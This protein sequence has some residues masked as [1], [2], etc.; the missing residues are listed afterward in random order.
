MFV[1]FSSSTFQLDL[2][3][4]F[5]LLKKKFIKPYIAER[6]SLLDVP[7]AQ[8]SLEEGEYIKGEIVCLPWKKGKAMTS[9]LK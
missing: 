4:L 9:K 8:K 6:I 7:A 2:D 1:L 5:H 3:I